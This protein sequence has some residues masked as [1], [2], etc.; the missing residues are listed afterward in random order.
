MS[1]WVPIGP[2]FVFAPRDAS[3]L[4]LS[5]RN[6]NGRQA[7]VQSITVDP[8]DYGT[9]YTVEAPTSGGNSAFRTTDGGASW[10]PLVDGLQQTDPANVNPSSITLNK[11]STGYVYLGTYSGRVYTSPGTRGDSW[12]TTFGNIGSG[13]FKL[14]IDPR[15]ASNPSTTTV[16]AA[17][18]NG[19]WKSTD[20][21]ATFIQ[22]LSGNL[23]DFAVRFPVDG[24]QADFYAGVENTGIFHATS[25]TASSSWTNLTNSVTSNLP[26]VGSFD[27]MR[28]DICR[29][30]PR[31]YIWFF[32][33]GSTASLYTAADSTSAWSAISMTSPPQP[34]YV[35][36][37][38]NQ[39]EFPGLYDDLFAV[40]PNSPGNGSQDILLFVFF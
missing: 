8:T 25:P 15:T 4:H 20:G 9:I 2:D 19:V 17:C 1:K 32:L 22:I 30:T 34:S 18:N 13:V 16:Y 26:S 27:G 38:P 31:P 40:A 3:F 11:V 23:A 33:K 5:R 37:F 12:N 29:S 14:V 21:A 24:S 28:I 7:V 39:P 36:W 35:G 10:T 6:E